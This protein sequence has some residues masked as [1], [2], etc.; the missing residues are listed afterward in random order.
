[1]SAPSGEGS[2]D[3]RQLHECAKQAKHETV[4]ADKGVKHWSARVGRVSVSSETFGGVLTQTFLVL[5]L[6]GNWFSQPSE[7]K[8]AETKFSAAHSRTYVVASWLE[9]TQQSCASVPASFAFLSAYVV[10]RSWYYIFFFH[11]ISRDVSSSA[12]RRS[13][14]R[15]FP[16]SSPSGS[17][18]P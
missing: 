14:S 12:L 4:R 6:S 7:G 8:A 11:L 16:R 13:S 2:S 3:Q 10:V 9:L 17:Q 18:L 1:M 5:S 15:A